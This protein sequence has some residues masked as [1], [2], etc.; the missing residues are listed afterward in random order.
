MTAATS[1]QNTK[2]GVSLATLAFVAMLMVGQ[3]APME[4]I[5]DASLDYGSVSYDTVDLDVT[6]NT[7]TTVTIDLA[8][9]VSNADDCKMYASG[10]DDKDNLLFSTPVSGTAFEVTM[11]STALDYENPLDAD[12]DNTFQFDVKAVCPGNV[13]STQTYSVHITNTVFAFDGPATAS[14]AEDAASGDS[15][16]STTSMDDT[17]DNCAITAGD[18]DGNFDIDAETCAITISDDA[19][20][21]FETEPSITLTVTA[22]TFGDLESDTMDVAVSVTD[23]DEAPV[24]DLV[25]TGTLTEDEVVTADSSGVSDEDGIDMS[26]ATYQWYSGSAAVAGAT[27]STY[28]LANS[29]TGQAMQVSMTYDDDSGRSTTVLSAASAAVTGV[30]D[31][32]PV[33]TTIP[34]Q[35][36]LEDASTDIDV[37]GYFSDDDPDATL[38][39]SMTGADFATIDPS[40]GIITAA[41]EQADVGDN[42]VIVSATDDGA[43]PLANNVGTTTSQ[44]FNLAVVN[45]NDDFGL[46]DY[47][48][49]V[50]GD[51]HD[52]SELSLGYDD[53]VTTT[54]CDITN[55]MFNG[56]ELC[57]VTVPSGVT[58]TMTFGDTTFYQSEFALGVY[59][60]ATLGLISS[61]GASDSPASLPSGDYILQITD[62]YDDGDGYLT[63]TYDSIST[64]ALDTTLIEDG[65]GLGTLSYQW[66]ADGTAID[67]ATSSTFTPDANDL[68][69]IGNTYTVEISQTDGMGTDE[70]MM[71]SSS[72]ALTLNPAGD[73]DGDG[74]TNDVDTDVD[75]DGTDNGD[76]AFEFDEHAWDD[77]DGDGMADVLDSSLTTVTTPVVTLCDITNPSGN[78]GASCTFTVPAGVTTNPVSF[79]DTTI[80]QSEFSMT[81]DDGTT[82]TSYGAGDADFTL[83]EGTYTISIDDTYDDGDGYVIVDYD[84]DPITVAAS[85]TPYGTTLD[86]DDDNDGTPDVDDAFPLDATEDTDADGDGIGANTDQVEN[87]ECYSLDTDGDGFPDEGTGVADCTPTLVEDSD[88]DGDGITNADDCDVS[89][90]TQ[91]YD[92]DGDG[93][94][95]SVDDDDDDD[96]VADWYDDYPL[97]D[98]AQY[99]ADGDGFSNTIDADDD[100]DGVT[101]DLDDDT[102]GDGYNNTDQGDGIVDWAP[103]DPDEWVDTDG[104]GLGDNYD[105]DDDNDDV[106]DVDDGCPLDDGASLDSDGDGHC[107]ATTDDDDDDDGVLDVDDDFPLDPHASVDTDGDGDADSLDPNLPTE[108]DYSTDD[109]LSFS[110]TGSSAY[111]EFTIPSTAVYGTLTYGDTTTWTSEF[112]MQLFSGTIAGGYSLIAEYGHGDGDVTLTPGDYIVQLSDSYGDGGGT[113]SVT[114]TYVSGSQPAQSTPFGTDLDHDDD[115]DGTLDT[116]DAFPLDECADTDTDGDRRSR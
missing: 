104:D 78:G 19:A 40:T 63:V 90:A 98:S 26:T 42:T 46:G 10:V 45:V 21:D 95:D 97:D 52:G 73:L 83:S 62:Q 57:S 61:Y 101:D 53:T 92:T 28:T 111:R 74:V 14:V 39:F 25:I 114:Y 44:S 109:L 115:D 33:S 66:Y 6:E 103:G 107:D 5:R 99:D 11:A 12:G 17:T 38:T 9:T 37:S 110:N 18:D 51:V 64:L 23:V 87:D 93:V 47:T 2:R 75:G 72:D 84:D 36:V 105:T 96:G 70:S 94:C 24:G 15:V 30:D 27:A 3:T 77:T 43:S 71:S 48:L 86:T 88:D 49:S 82:T 13:A 58:A 34:D 20:L 1:P 108:D 54:L 65:D 35:A 55:P 91:M 41:P 100:N 102:D 81:V 56:G 89:D 80:Y 29:D 67:G 85:E 4:Y 112:S 69:L 116:D 8:S 7:D 32:D 59:D 79:G 106:L 76:D 68:D 50:F 22:S 31:N 16:W 60:A 113:A